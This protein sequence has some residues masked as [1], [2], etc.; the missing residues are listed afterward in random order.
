MNDCFSIEILF[1]IWVK[2]AVETVVMI[3]IVPRGLKMIFSVDQPV[4]W[5]TMN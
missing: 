3:L 2:L 5:E 4:I 1:K